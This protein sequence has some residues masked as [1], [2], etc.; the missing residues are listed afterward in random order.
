MSTDLEYWEQVK[1][2]A[3]AINV[4]K[5][6]EALISEL[7]NLE[8]ELKA[9]ITKLKSDKI[10]LESENLKIFQSTEAL[11]KRDTSEIENK[12]A[13]YDSKEAEIKAK[14]EELK[15]KQEEINIILNKSTILNQENLNLEARNKQLSNEAESK[16]KE[17]TYLKS[18]RES[19]L[20]AIEE[21]QAKLNKD[22]FHLETLKNEIQK[23]SAEN[24]EILKEVNR[25]KADIQ[26]QFDELH[27]FKQDN[28]ILRNNAQRDINSSD[29]LLWVLRN[30]IWVF[31][32]EL[33]RFIQINGSQVRIADFTNEHR[34]IIIDDLK[35]QIAEN[36]ETIV[37]VKE[38]EVVEI[39]EDY[40]LLTK[41]QII[42][43]LTELWI[44]HNSNS[45]KTDLIALLPQ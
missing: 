14:E 41:S 38:E 35:K 32:Q 31:R 6:K 7:S 34:Q 26:N 27:K 40:S 37:E 2:I 29:Y 30:M 18:Q 24:N 17:A 44:E 12:K 3:T 1:K 43:K 33:T 25:S 9:S 8:K 19:E 28:E 11:N 16:V 23:Q 39:K 22:K 13:F 5:E 15:T 36:P 4:L 45:L 42:S 10:A 21:A 20:A